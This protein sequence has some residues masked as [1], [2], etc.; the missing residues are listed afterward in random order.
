[1]IKTIFLIFLSWQK[2]YE[3]FLWRVGIAQGQGFTHGFRMLVD[4]RPL[5]ILRA[6][7]RIKFKEVMFI[8]NGVCLSTGGA[9]ISPG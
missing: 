2:L 6:F 8:N 3:S 5:K 1:M 4:N 7:S 9:G